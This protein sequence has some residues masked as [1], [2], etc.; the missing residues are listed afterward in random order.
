MIVD[1]GERLSWYDG[2]TLLDI[3]ENAPAAHTRRA[4]GL[5][6][7]GAVRVPTAPE[8]ANP[9]LHDYRGFMG[10]VRNRR[11]RGGRRGH[12]TALR[13]QQPGQGKIELGGVAAARHPRAV[14]DP[15]ARRQIDDISRGDLIVKSAGRGE[16][17]GR[18]KPRCAGCRDPLSPAR[19]Y[20]VR[21][22]TRG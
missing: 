18:S 13:R 1:R 14:G 22:T 10:R 7:P 6:L 5:P 2:P 12:R 21:H 3:L 11:G 8:S 15:A 9:E 20:L 19:T 17:V 4:E 16:P